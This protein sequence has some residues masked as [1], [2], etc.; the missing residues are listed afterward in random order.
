MITANSLPQTTSWASAFG[1]D[2]LRNAYIGIANC[3]GMQ[4][5][6]MNKAGVASSIPTLQHVWNEVLQG[7]IDTE[8]LIRDLGNDYYIEKKLL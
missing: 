1:G 2:Q 3:I 7:S 5:F 8:G 6:R 4:A